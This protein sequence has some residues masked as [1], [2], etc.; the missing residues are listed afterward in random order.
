MRE[1]LVVNSA[2][3]SAS[4]RPIRDTWFALGLLLCTS[5]PVMAA[6]AWE[7]SDGALFTDLSYSFVTAKGTVDTNYGDGSA[8]NSGDGLML[9]ATGLVPDVP[10]YVSARLKNETVHV[11]SQSGI[12]QG[13]DQVV[14]RTR[15]GAGVYL[16]AGRRRAVAL[17]AAFYGTETQAPGIEGS[18]DGVVFGVGFATWTPKVQFHGFLRFGT[19]DGQTQGKG[20]TVSGELEYTGLEFRWAH[21]LFDGWGYFLGLDIESTESDISDPS[22][23]L[24]GTTKDEVTS[25]NVG[26]SYTVH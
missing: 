2:I 13:F 5:Q 19:L 18:T 6:E 17:E 9:Q 11:E 10:I 4:I 15:V 7:L 20:Q 1:H 22:Q 21:A 3:V 8:S 25:L 16:P 26:L 24:V 14:D 23:G 12:A